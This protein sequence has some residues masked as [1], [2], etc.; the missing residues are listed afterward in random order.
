MSD[1][2]PTLFHQFSSYAESNVDS[3]VADVSL[4]C[5]Q[6]FVTGPGVIYRLRFLAGSTSGAALFSIGASSRFYAAG[7]YVN[8]VFSE[9]LALQIAS[10]L[11][12]PSGPSERGERLEAPRPNP[13]RPGDSA[14]V[15]FTLPTRAAAVLELFDL[16]GRRVARYDAG[17][18]P[19]GR[20]LVRWSVPGL[21]AGH[22]QLRLSAD[23][24]IVAR[25]AWVILR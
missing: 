20:T 13:L 24:R 21:S 5:N 2:C 16:A 11:D 6:T 7:V 12:V 1:A 23:G 19:A 10:S 8:P 4:L 25:N 22:Y 14:S 3:T 18:V 17:V 9:G 15:A